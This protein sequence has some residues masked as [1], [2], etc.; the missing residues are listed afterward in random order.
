MSRPLALAVSLLLLAICASAHA[1]P[2]APVDSLDM[3]VAQAPV[4]LQVEGR[5]SLVYE[6]HL[7][8]FG[9][10]PLRLSELRVIDADSG[11]E[12]AGWN[13]AGLTARTQRVARAGEA[14]TLGP[15]ER[16]V[17]YLE[18]DLA[19]PRPRRLRHRIG[20]TAI[21]DSA[22]EPAPP[23]LTVVEGAEIG[24]G[25]PAVAQLGPPL[26]GGP[27]VA[28]HAPQWP[29]GHRRVFYALDGRARLPGRHAIDWV[30]VDPSG[31]IAEGDA[32]VPA[33]HLGYGAPVLAVA[34]ARVA[35]VRD[36]QAE[37]ATVSANPRHDFDHA[38]GNYVVLA[39]PDGRYATYEHL[40]PGSVRVRE[41]D[42]VRAGQT[43][44]ALGFSG[45]STGPHLHFHLADGRA[46]LA[47]EGLAYGFAGFRLLGHYRPLDRLGS[48][49]WQP[50][51]DEMSAER[52]GEFPASNAVVMFPR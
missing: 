24:I 9:R 47:A 49:P 45:D 38:A 52:A 44:A 33:H 11:R 51:G 22:A 28:I 23:A 41:G 19:P 14:G 8:Q 36:G 15:G 30:R 10:T 20:A 1:S 27:W 7:T 40:R 18:F 29:R 43:L 13:G 12:V 21:G 34:D 32:E 2:A 48:R 4:P 6:L 37:S 3:S 42:T 39:L 35:A 50:L 26:R 5:S 17:V 16:A 31:R 46:P 25:A